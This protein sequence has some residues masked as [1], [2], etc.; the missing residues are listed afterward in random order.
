[1]AI[2]RGVRHPSR[3]GETAPVWA[4]SGRK[5]SKLP[6]EMVKSKSGLTCGTCKSAED[7]RV[8]EHHVCLE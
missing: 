4:E 5:N 8:R 2:R 1:M 6:P 3:A 7:L